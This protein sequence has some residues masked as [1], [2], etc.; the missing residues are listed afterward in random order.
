MR[1]AVTLSLAFTLTIFH[2]P[3]SAAE[4]IKAAVSEGNNVTV[5]YD[6]SSVVT[7]GKLK[8]AWSI[9][10]YA[11]PQEITLPGA[12]GGKTAFSAMRELQYFSCSDRQVSTIQTT[13][14]R[15]AAARDMIVSIQRPA[16]EVEMAFPREVVPESLT[17]ALFNVVCK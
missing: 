15:D 13:F 6:R 7:V 8:K 4:W 12:K 5:L 1:T 2:G 14:Y 3:T 17:E 16:T 10:S 11:V 9:W